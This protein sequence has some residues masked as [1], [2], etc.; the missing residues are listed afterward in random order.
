MQ[1][2]IIRKVHLRCPASPCGGARDVVPSVF[3]DFL[4]RHRRTSSLGGE[5]GPVLCLDGSCDVER[6]VSSHTALLK[7]H[8]GRRCAE[9][10]PSHADF[11]DTDLFGWSLQSDAGVFN[12]EIYLLGSLELKGDAYNS[13]I[14]M[15]VCV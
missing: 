3:E 14:V 2:K 5:A 15:C 1:L 7:A 9:D 10:D 4:C 6:A 11:I 13:I 12:I 8:S